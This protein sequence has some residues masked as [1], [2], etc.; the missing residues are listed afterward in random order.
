[1]S[2]KIFLVTPGEQKKHGNALRKKG[3][4][5]AGYAGKVLIDN[6]FSKESGLIITSPLA[7]DLQTAQR[8]HDKAKAKEDV[9]V[10]ERVY[11]HTNPS[12]NLGQSALSGSVA[13]ALI[14]IPAYQPNEVPVAVVMC[15]ERIALALGTNGNKIAPGGVYGFSFETDITPKPLRVNPKK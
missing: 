11:D 5:Q 13:E 12:S 4:K 3:K 10:A 9:V 1:M 14:S 6:G 2:R 7:T 8:I 15:P